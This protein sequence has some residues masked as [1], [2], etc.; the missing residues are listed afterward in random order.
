[1]L[2][3]LVCF[4]AVIQ[5]RRKY[6]AL[7]WNIPYQWMTSDLVCAQQ[8]LKMYIDEQPATP[9]DVRRHHC[10]AHGGWDP[11]QHSRQ[12][13]CS[14]AFLPRHAGSQAL[15]TVTADVVFGGRITD[16]MDVRTARTVL[17]SFFRPGAVERGESYC[18]QLDETFR[19][20]APEEGPISVY[21]DYIGTM[22]LVDRPEIFGLHVNADISSQQKETK[23]SMDAI[24]S[25]QPRTTARGGGKSNDEVVEDMAAQL[26]RQL[27]PELSVK[28]AHADVFRKLEDG[29]M[30]P[31][32]I[33][34]GHE[35]H[36]FNSLV[37]EMRRGLRDLGRAI[38]GQVVMSAQLD[39]MYA[40]F[41]Y[42]QVPQ[43]WGE[44][45]RGYPSLKPLASWF[46]DFTDRVAF[47]RGWLAGGPPSTFWISAFFFPQ[48]FLTSAL[49]MH[50]RRFRLAI[51][52]LV[53]HTHVRDTLGLEDTHA[54]PPEGVYIHGML[55]EG[56]R[57]DS[58]N[59]CVAESNPGEL[60]APLP[61]VW[62]KPAMLDD[63]R[64][65]GTYECP[66]YKTNVRAGTLSTT[67]HSTNHVCN[68]DLPSREPP[69]HWIRRGVALI[70][71]T[72][73]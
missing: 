41:L 34:L 61:V 24:I 47:V 60:F 22:P 4:N 37:S 54:G 69:G 9:Y 10:A 15:M 30:N 8:N 44:G 16:K 71:G 51:D 11:Q 17:E 62:L 49:Q 48:G 70:S 13:F 12:P 58:S 28:E 40:N 64:P 53:F 1:M 31:L 33:F 67:G 5:E 63:A 65:T 35:M 59:S 38:R 25:V 36:K 2:F 46:K 20:A 66:F 3:G 32:G 50:A 42:Q 21:R 73:D 45:G 52:Q 27:P 56:A 72:N 7:G 23:E 6:G 26:E 43:P 68:F 14:A 19:Y 18:P 55:L 39:A 57:W 29:S